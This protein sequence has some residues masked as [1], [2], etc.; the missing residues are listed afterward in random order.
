LRG[1]LSEI[2]NKYTSV[3]VVVMQAEAQVETIT[4]CHVSVVQNNRKA[5]LAAVTSAGS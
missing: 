3:L 1:L 2:Q 4:S 5:S